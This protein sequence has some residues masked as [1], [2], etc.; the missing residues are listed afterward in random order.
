[1]RKAVPPRRR[2]ALGGNL[3]GFPRELRDAIPDLPTSVG[4][5]LEIESVH[6]DASET[7]LLGSRVHLRV[8]VKETGK[9]QGQFVIRIE[10]EPAAARGLSETLAQLA[11]RAEKPVP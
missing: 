6:G 1:M 4:R 11:A 5:F 10:L 3:I 8:V 2:Y 9:L 7:R